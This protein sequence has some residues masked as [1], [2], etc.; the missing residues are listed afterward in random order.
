V[1]ES[2]DFGRRAFQEWR[3]DVESDPGDYMFLVPLR[4]GRSSRR[5]TSELAHFLPVLDYLE[6]ELGQVLGSSLPPFA[7]SYTNGRDGTRGAVWCTQIYPDMMSDLGGLRG[8]ISV[9]REIV[10]EVVARA[11][12]RTSIKALGL[13]ASLPSITKFGLA[14]DT[15]LPT[16]TGHGC[17]VA[18]MIQTILDRVEALDGEQSIGILGLGSIGSAVASTLAQRQDVRR[19]RVFDTKHRLVDEFVRS[20]QFTSVD[21]EPAESLADLLAHSTVVASAITSTVDLDEI[22]SDLA[23]LVIIDDSQPGAFSA[24]QV[25]AAGGTLNWVIGSDDTV[26]S[27]LTRTGDFTYGAEGV[28]STADLWGCEAEVGAISLLNRPELCL[29]RP[30]G[31]ADIPAFTQ[32]LQEVG[33][34][35][36]QPQ[37]FGECAPG[38]LPQGAVGG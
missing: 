37:A 3:G 15:D 1:E 19:L 38:V 23:G 25:A 28:T 20:H 9:G 33:V 11:S 29:D 14:I 5:Y 32:L 21:I 26:D 6:P 12:Q 35:V 13:G 30:V 4:M 7:A 34:V 27:A 18:L 31:S 16:T 22:G 24:S 2:A 17:T 36:A 8:A 10:N